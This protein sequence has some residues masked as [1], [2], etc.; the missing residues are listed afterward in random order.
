MG[1]TSL[2]YTSNHNV[3]AYNLLDSECNLLCISALC[4]VLFR[5]NK[6]ED[7]TPGGPDLMKFSHLCIGATLQDDKI[8]EPYQQS[9]YVLTYSQGYA[10]IHFKVGEIPYIKLEPKIFILQRKD[11]S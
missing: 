3:D 5:Y 9:H 11:W 4:F 6:T 8:M 2:W 1:Q 10:G 7:L